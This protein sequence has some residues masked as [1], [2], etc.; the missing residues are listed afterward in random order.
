VGNERYG[1]NINSI[2]CGRRNWPKLT[3]TWCPS[4]FG[5]ATGQQ[6]NREPTTRRF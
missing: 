5:A 6:P 3:N 4:G 2:G 1:W